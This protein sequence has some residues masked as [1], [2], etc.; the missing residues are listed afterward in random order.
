MFNTLLSRRLQ[1]SWAGYKKVMFLRGMGFKTFIN[2]KGFILLKIGMT[3]RPR[4]FFDKNSFFIRVKKFQRI[5]LKSLF[6]EEM[7]LFINH[8]RLFRAPDVYCGKGFFFK[9]QRLK[10]KRGKRK[11]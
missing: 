10:L 3:N 4:L 1:G 6:Y 2:S 9:G 8:L 7:V 11:R 5:L